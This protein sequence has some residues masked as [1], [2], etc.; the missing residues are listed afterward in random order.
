MASPIAASAAATVM[1]KKTKIMP[2][3]EPSMF[4]AAM[5]VRLTP[6]SISSMH[7]KTMIA[8]RLVMTP[9]APMVKSAPRRARNRDSLVYR[10]A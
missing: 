10:A 6:F 2:S 3:I 1:M 9:M 7:M 8:F 5:K 4:P